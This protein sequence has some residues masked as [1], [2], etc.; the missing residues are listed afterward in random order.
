MAAD[1][2]LTEPA[3]PEGELARRLRDA[4]RRVAAA[5]LAPGDRERYARRFVVI[6]DLAKRDVGHAAV[7]LDAFLTDL[8]ADS[9]AKSRR[10]I[11]QCD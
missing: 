4:Y 6:C 5:P 9:D 8:D 11:A 7:R 10:N 1:D 2:G 3:G